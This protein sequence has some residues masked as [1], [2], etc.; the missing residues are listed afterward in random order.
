MSQ[1]HAQTRSNYFRVKSLPAFWAWIETFG[2]QVIT[3]DEDDSLVGFMGQ[4]DIPAFDPE[5]NEEINFTRE[6][7]GHLAEDEVAIFQEV[8][9][10]N[11]RY[12]NG[13]AVAV[14]HLGEFEEISL[15]DIHDLARKLGQ[16]VTACEY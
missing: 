16:N 10:E 12:L 4:R 8:G 6:L 1:Y 15:F 3:S 13:S 7:A 9:S 14:N 5:T 2:F 11:L